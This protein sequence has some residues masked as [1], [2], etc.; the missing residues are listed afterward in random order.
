MTRF[1][2]HDDYEHRRDAERDA[3]RGTPDRD[4]YDRYSS[5]PCD[6]VY[7]EAYDDECRRQEHRDQIQR[8]HEE[9]E[10]RR[11]R[12]QEAERDAQEQYEMQ[13]MQEEQERQDEPQ[14][15]MDE[16]HELDE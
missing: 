11:I 4:Y 13:Q 1:Y 16:T 12:R 10:R 9:D 8:D 15:T 5:D 3:R 6:Q 2:C 7:T 14:P